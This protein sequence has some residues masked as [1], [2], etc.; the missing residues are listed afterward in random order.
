MERLQFQFEPPVL[1]DSYALASTIVHV[2]PK[3]IYHQSLPRRKLYP[4]HREFLDSPTLAGSAIS[5]SGREQ[6]HLL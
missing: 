4:Q 3:G 5:P 1:P 6:P 2:F